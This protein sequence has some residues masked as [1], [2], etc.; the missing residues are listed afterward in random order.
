MTCLINGRSHV[1]FNIFDRRVSQKDSRN[2]SS[3][4]INGSFGSFHSSLNFVNSRP[5]S[6]SIGPKSMVAFF[7]HDLFSFSTQISV[8]TLIMG[9][10]VSQ[11]NRS[12]SKLFKAGY[13]PQGSV[14]KLLSS[15]PTSTSV[16]IS[17]RH[18]NFVSVVSFGFI[19]SS[20]H[21]SV[22]SH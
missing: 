19:G 4:T 21:R 5:V 9:K 16:I 15:L 2:C 6:T 1:S 22:I 14:V 11:S 7:S 10:F 18:V 13:F 3:L 12:R 20:S 8:F 17:S